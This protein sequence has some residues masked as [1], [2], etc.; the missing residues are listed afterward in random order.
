MDVNYLTLS[1]GEKK[2]M[3]AK[4]K[5]VHRGQRAQ[6]PSFSVIFPYLA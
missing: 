3:Q 2:E 1:S 4:G 5:T 6:I